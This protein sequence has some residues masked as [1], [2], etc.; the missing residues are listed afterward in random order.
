MIIIGGLQLI[1]R[2]KFV[3]YLINLMQFFPYKKMRPLK[4]IHV[5]ISGKKMK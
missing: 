1:I 4:F 2:H 5:I 3:V